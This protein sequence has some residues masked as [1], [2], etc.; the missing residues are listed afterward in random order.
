[1]VVAVSSASREAG[2]TGHREG[3]K[4]LCANGKISEY[5]VTMKVTFVL[6]G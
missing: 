5:R 1:M 6:K 3:Q 2:R 4:L